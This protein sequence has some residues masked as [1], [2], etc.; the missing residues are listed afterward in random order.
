MRNRR[1]IWLS[2]LL[3]PLP[4]VAYNPD[5][6]RTLGQ[7]AELFALSIATLVAFTTA[8]SW[9][10]RPYSRLSERGARVGAWAWLT[11]ALVLIGWVVGGNVLGLGCAAACVLVAAFA[12]ARDEWQTASFL[13]V[14][15]IAVLVQSIVGYVATHRQAPERQVV[16]IG[17]DGTTWKLVD[18]ND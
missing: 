10:A 7:W 9:I 13:A 18:C 6:A 17:L 12:R 1:W 3:L 11:T 15:A 5:F 4:L 16:M 14:A 2:A 8:G